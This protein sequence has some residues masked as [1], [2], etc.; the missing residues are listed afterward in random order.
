MQVV[1]S[2]PPFSTASTL[3]DTPRIGLTAGKP[4]SSPERGDGLA[5]PVGGHDFRRSLTRAQLRA[6]QALA[7]N[8]S[9]LRDLARVEVQAVLQRDEATDA[10]LSAASSLIDTVN[11][12]S[13]RQAK[14]AR[15][16]KPRS[17]QLWRSVAGLALLVGVG[18]VIAPRALSRLYG[19]PADG[20][21]GTAAL[22]WK[23]FGVRTV[24]I[25]AAALV[26]SAPVRQLVIP[27][28]IFDQ[29]VFFQAL[30]TRSVPRKSAIMAMATSGAIIA[31]S[32]AASR[33]EQSER[34]P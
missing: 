31:L 24:T 10:Y 9:L 8:R 11:R 7:P 4:P 16:M 34:Q 5:R 33:L 17:E 23:M 3:I 27:V 21:T 29:I 25:G 18:S 6:I 26:G 15:S 2:R 19:M 22:G 14:S 32:L 28:Q 12:G 20:M 1:R 13:Q 30:L